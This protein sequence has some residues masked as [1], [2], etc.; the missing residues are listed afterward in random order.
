MSALTN[1]EDFNYLAFFTTGCHYDTRE[2]TGVT[3]ADEE[4]INK[5][6]ESRGCGGKINLS[7]NKPKE[8][9]NLNKIHVND[10]KIAAGTWKQWN[11]IGNHGAYNQY[12]S[13]DITNSDGSITINWS[14]RPEASK[15]PGE[16]VT[17]RV[18]YY[19]G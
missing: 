6:L 12:V 9:E 3:L 4:T 19:V 8:D 17:P 11:V 5:W 15:V 14:S 2:K 13:T 10:I 18:E 1:I 7:D 16:P